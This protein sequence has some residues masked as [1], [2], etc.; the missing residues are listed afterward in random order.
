MEQQNDRGQAPN[1][2]IED[3]DEL[4]IVDPTT[5]TTA[6][7]RTLFAAWEQPELLVAE[8]RESFK[9]LREI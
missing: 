3:A 6:H 4:P 5:N 1:G 2:R 7:G 9:S 8:L